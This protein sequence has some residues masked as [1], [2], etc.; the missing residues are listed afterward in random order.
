MIQPYFGLKKPPFQ[1]E[2]KAT[3]LFESYD[4]KEAFTRLQFLK[5]NRG[6]FCLTGE[7]G[8]GKTTVLRRFVDG[9]NPQTHMHAYTPH[10]TVSKVELYRQLNGLLN[11]PGR[12]HKS[13][14]FAQ[15]QKAILDLHEHHGKT[16][17]IILDE[18]HLMDCYTLQELILIT[19]FQMDSKV[20][21]VL[22]LIGQP[23]FKEILKRRIHEPLNQRITLRYHMAGI[24][25]ANE[26]R[27]YVLHHLKIAGRTDPLFD[28][29]SYEVLHRLALGLP[30]KI[31]NLAIA[32][33]T[34]AMVRREKMVT[35]DHII[36]ATD[37]I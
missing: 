36:K 13:D 10:A 19:N 8:S 20:P 28:D 15:I 16:P 32:A 37:G 34:L 33:M 27:D 35:P 31:G 17:V 29:A 9:L 12:L 3:A 1:K 23:D 14:L 6:I 11:L 30:R 22:V 25:D 26:T 4:L 18:C 5:Q 24:I 21:F 7:P 2:L